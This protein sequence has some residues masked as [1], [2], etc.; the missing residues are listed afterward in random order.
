MRRYW[1]RCVKDNENNVLGVLLIEI[2]T[3][4]CINKVASRFIENY[5][6]IHLHWKTFYITSMMTHTRNYVQKESNDERMINKFEE[7]YK[8]YIYIW[9]ILYQ[10]FFGTSLITPHRQ[11]VTWNV[12]TNTDL[13]T[14]KV[15]N[16]IWITCFINI[17]H[18]ELS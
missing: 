10:I 7:K 1:A 11:Y 9:T 5:C 3:R 17:T 13:M 8:N 14:W 4:E 18:S 2:K 15:S 12:E 6:L 16:S